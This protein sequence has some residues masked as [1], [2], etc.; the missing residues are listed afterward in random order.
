MFVHAV[1]DGIQGRAKLK[2]DATFKD[3]LGRIALGFSGD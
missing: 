3:K 2:K 1:L